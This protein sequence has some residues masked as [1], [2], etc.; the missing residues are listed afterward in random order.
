MA[1]PAASS[2]ASLAANAMVCRAPGAVRRDMNLQANSLIFSFSPL[3]GRRIFVQNMKT[4]LRC[5]SAAI[6]ASLGLCGALVT[7]GASAGELKEFK[8]WAVGCDNL[9]NCTAIGFVA[10]EAQAGTY[11]RISR[12][13]DRDAQ[14]VVR[15][16]SMPDSD[17]HAPS[18]QL[19]L[20]GVPNGAAPQRLA[21]RVVDDFVDADLNG[22][23]AMKLIDDLRNAQSLSVELFDGASAKGAKTVSLSGAAAAL[24]YMDAQQLRV[25]TVTALVAKGPAAASTIRDVPAVP[26]FVGKVLSPMNAP[27]RLP[28]GVGKPDETCDAGEASVIAFKAP[29]GV[30]LIGVCQSSGAYNTSYSFWVVRAGSQKAVAADFD[31]G[32][33]EVVNP[34]LSKDGLTLSTFDKGRGVGDCG[35]SAEFT[36]DG[37]AF[38]T[39]TESE[40][41]ECLGVPSDDWPVTYTAVLRNRP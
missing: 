27:K 2:A 13:G 33:G 34:G 18:L 35:D 32:G 6:A 23:A 4:S 31:S 21:A 38:R 29:D 20:S 14:P 24:R 30:S 25:G 12:G 28:P 41:P 11:I 7:S 1:N 3:T 39:L 10:D 17:V 37:T 36:W 26:H 9:R 40:M 19:S 16:A 15:I 22:G 5:F 8:D